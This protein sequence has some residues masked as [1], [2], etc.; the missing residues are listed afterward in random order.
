MNLWVAFAGLL[1]GLIVWSV[2]VSR[3]TTR[4][5]E[6]SG[7]PNQSLAANN[8]PPAK[9]GLFVFL[10]VITSLFA[11]FISAYYMRMGHGHVHDMGDWHS[12]ADPP[13]LWLNTVLLFLASIAMQWA[14]RAAVRQQREHAKTALAAGG[15]LTALF[16]A[17]Q[18]LAWR[19]LRAAGYFINNPAVAFFYVLT[20]VHGLHLLG[21]LGVWTRT[22][23]RTWQRDIELIDVRLSIALCAMYW[24]YLLLVWLALFVVLLST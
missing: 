9:M 8:I 17:G 10:A 6:V 2:L 18:L 20:A 14:K 5:W 24:H 23:R 4:T 3:L 12:I 19:Q 22:A 21:G 11:L 1:A 7:A 13:I 16:L 15:L